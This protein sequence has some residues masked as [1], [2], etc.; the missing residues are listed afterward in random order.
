M[1]NPVFLR[2]FSVL[3]EERSFTRAAEALAMSQPGVS[4][5][6]KALEDYYRTPLVSR[7]GRHFE[8]TDAGRR[9]ADYTRSLFAEHDRFRTSLAADEPERGLC[10]FS[11]PGSFGIKMYTFLLRINKQH[12]GLSIHFAYAPNANV[13]KDVLE[14]RIDVGFM[15]QAVDEANVHAEAFAEERLCLALPKGTKGTT[16]AQLKELGFINHPDGFHHASRILAK[17]FPSDY[18]TMEDFQIRGFSNQ[19]VS[20]ILEPVAMGLGFTALPE[21]ACLSFAGRAKIRIEPLPKPVIDQIYWVQKRGRQLPSRFA[22][23]KAEYGKV[24]KNLATVDA[25]L[26]KSTAATER[27]PVKAKARRKDRKSVV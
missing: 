8:L 23:L 9:L 17:N 14:E 4:Q 19:I 27:L 1:I 5:H 10:R 3:A 16:W 24:Y 11:S 12:P 20:S 7:E 21:S 15:S 13:L 22:Y 18:V 2:T 25:S 6:L 26:L